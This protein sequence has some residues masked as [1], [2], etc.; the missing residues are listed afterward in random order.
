M[1]V[2]GMARFAYGLLLPAM[3]DDLAWTYA[4]A[5]AMNMANALGYLVGTVLSL[6]RQAASMRGVRCV[7]DDG[8]DMASSDGGGVTRRPWPPPPFSAAA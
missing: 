8:G 2:T 1:A 5:G 7:A 6:H 3:R 4:Q